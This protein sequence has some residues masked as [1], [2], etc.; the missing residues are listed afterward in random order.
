MHARVGIFWKAYGSSLKIMCLKLAET[1]S[2]RFSLA[3]LTR[4]AAVQHCREVFFSSSSPRL[5]SRTHGI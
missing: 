4:G 3:S 5:L 2:S 1:I